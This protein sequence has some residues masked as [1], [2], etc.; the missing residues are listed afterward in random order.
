MQGKQHFVVAVTS[1]VL[2][3]FFS[4]PVARAGCGCEKPPPLPASVRPHFAYPGATVIVF[5]SSLVPG[6][7]YEVRFQ[8]GTKNASAA[9][10]AEAVLARDQADGVE[11]PQL[12]VEVPGLP[13]GPTAIE[14]KRQGAGKT[15]VAIPDTDFT[16][17]APPVVL[18]NGD[19]VIEVNG[20]RTGVDRNGTAYVTFDLSNVRAATSFSGFAV[21]MPFRLRPEDTKIYNLQGYYFEALSDDPTIAGVLDAPPD[22]TEESDAVWYWRHDFQAYQ[23][24]HVPGGTYE[25]SADD[26]D[27]WHADGTPHI[28]HNRIVFAIPA[29]LR[30]GSQLPAGRTKPFKLH[31]EQY[32]QP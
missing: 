17:V 28:D 5:G 12:R 14:V 9:V 32:N 29:T 6:D 18:P 2:A 13:M 7:Q 8:S 16:V 19:A 22:E 15:E 26:P 10:E 1:G 24:A 30:D 27:Y 20:Y 25:L 23:D 3:L 21:A 4:V 11:K 31:L